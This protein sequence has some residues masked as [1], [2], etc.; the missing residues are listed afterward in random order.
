MGI[1]VLIHTNELNK[2]LNKKISAYAEFVMY[3]YVHPN[4]SLLPVDLIHLHKL[5]S[6]LPRAQP[7]RLLVF[8]H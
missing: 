2:I 6:D 3:D 8:C 1:N 7:T 5:Y 4:P